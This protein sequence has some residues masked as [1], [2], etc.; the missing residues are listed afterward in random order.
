MPL[1]ENKYLK[2]LDPTL[3]AKYH[4]C[5]LGIRAYYNDVGSVTGNDL[6]VYDDLIVRCIGNE[7]A[8]FRAS[9]DPG[10]LCIRGENPAPNPNGC[11]LLLNGVHLFKLGQHSGH[12]ALVQ[13]ETFYIRR[14]NKDGTMKPGKF[15]AGTGAGINLHSGGANLN[16]VNIFSAGCQIIY[17]PEGYF[18]ETWHEFFD[19]IPVAMKAAGQKFA[20]YRLMHREEM[21]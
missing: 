11:A 17:S 18:K 8:A 12:D 19:P 5:L 9:C 3:T 2:Q 20:P 21:I 7:T 1:F 16:D 14:L 15:A 4:V 6:G 10:W 13:G